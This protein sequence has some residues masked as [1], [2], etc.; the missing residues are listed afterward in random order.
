MRALDAGFDVTA[1]RSILGRKPQLEAVDRDGKDAYSVAAS[2]ED[3]AQLKVL[4]DDTREGG[5]QQG[6]Q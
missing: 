5:R 6:E 1:I 3:A 2:R 4:L